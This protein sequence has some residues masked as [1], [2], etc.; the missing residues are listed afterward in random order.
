LNVV[1]T[2]FSLKFQKIFLPY[3]LLSTNY[4]SDTSSFFVFALRWE[5][6][7]RSI[8][9]AAI[10]CDKCKRYTSPINA[11]RTRNGEHQFQRVVMTIKAGS[12]GHYALP[13]A[14]AP[15]IPPV[16]IHGGCLRREFSRRTENSRRASLQEARSRDRSRA[17]SPRGDWNSTCLRIRR[18]SG[19]LLLHLDLAW[20]G[21]IPGSITYAVTERDFLSLHRFLVSRWFFR[22]SICNWSELR[23]ARKWWMEY[24]YH[25]HNESSCDHQGLDKRGSGLYSA[26][27]NCGWA[28]KQECRLSLSWRTFRVL[29]AKARK[30]PRSIFEV[31]LTYKISKF[32]KLLTLA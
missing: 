1:Y 4:I 28:E 6:N 3:F 11:W 17:L 18:D 2:L 27:P 32:L 29:N 5:C 30:S 10:Q 22:D 14:R 15:I 23:M 19:L 9:S 8:N 7:C 25:G 13:R 12:D 16:Q 31:T 24:W 21:V 26:I 20:L